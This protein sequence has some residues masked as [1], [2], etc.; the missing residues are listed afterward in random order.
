LRNYT[1]TVESNDINMR[2]SILVFLG[3]AAV[4]MASPTTPE[5]SEYFAGD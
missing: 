3:L 2:F 4:A 5:F 1:K